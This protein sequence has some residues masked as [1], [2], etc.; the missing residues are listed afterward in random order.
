[1][2]LNESMNFS[3]IGRWIVKQ[4]GND[5]T[6]DQIEARLKAKFAWEDGQV[7]S[8]TDP[9][10]EEKRFTPRNQRVKRA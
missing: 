2:E 7:Y 1:M 8:T 4:M 3:D 6:R 9:Y 5:L 10:F